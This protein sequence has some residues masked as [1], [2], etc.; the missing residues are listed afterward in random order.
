MVSKL[1]MSLFFNIAWAFPLFLWNT[2]QDEIKNGFYRFTLGLSTILWGLACILLYFNIADS[3]NILLI[4]GLAVGA[5]LLIGS[6][7]AIIWNKDNIALFQISAICVVLAG[8][9]Y[10]LHQSVIVKVD[11]LNPAFVIGVFCLSNVLFSMVLG[12]WFLNVPHLKITRLQKTVSILGIF[13][14]IRCIWDFY[15]I[16][17]KSGIYREGIAIDGYTY[18]I[19]ID[20]IFLWIALFFGLIAPIILNFMTA[21]TLNIFST[22]AAT[23]LLYINVVLILMAEMIF[24][25]YLLQYNWV[26]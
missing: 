1:T 10:F 8:V 26:L 25:F 5:L 13:L 24:K 12:H 4:F 18:L 3:N 11:Y 2:P 7:T 15:S 20:G 21:K 17:S 9:S 6:F 14:I 22:Q 23:G 16:Y 19:S